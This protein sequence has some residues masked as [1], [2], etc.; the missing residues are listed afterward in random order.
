MLIQ[1]ADLEYDLE[2][3]DALLE[4]LGTGREAFVLGSRHSGSVWKMRQFSGQ[5]SL[6]AVPE[7]RP[8]GVHHAGQCARS[9]SG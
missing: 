9:A 2:D 8:L 5:A 6:S 4:P 1:D 7:S 3:Y